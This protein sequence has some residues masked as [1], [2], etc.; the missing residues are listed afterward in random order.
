[1]SND[2]KSGSTSGEGHSSGS[3][4]RSTDG[5]VVT[6][7]Q[8][9]NQGQEKGGSPPINAPQGSPPGTGESDAEAE[10]SNVIE[11]PGG[12]DRFNRAMQDYDPAE[13]RP[14]LAEHHVFRDKEHD[15]YGYF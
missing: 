15:E 1:M 14:Q 12:S 2:E 7:G 5:V 10:E 3:G 4:R 11:Y 9:D 13:L 8:P 6:Q